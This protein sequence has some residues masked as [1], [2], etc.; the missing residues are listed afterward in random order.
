MMHLR[1]AQLQRLYRADDTLFLS[2]VWSRFVAAL[3][4]ILGFCITSVLA[5]VGPA[6][7]RARVCILELFALAIGFAHVSP[8]NFN[9]AVK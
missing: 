2:I 6:K 9:Q 4:G 5:E 8:V 3:Q 1:L 7:V